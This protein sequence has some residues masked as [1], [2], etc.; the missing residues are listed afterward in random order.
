MAD[1]SVTIMEI[2]KKVKDFV[3]DREWE[4]FHTPRNI[5]ESVV[6]ESA[7]LLEIFQWGL[8]DGTSMETKKRIEEE[9]ADI[10]IYLLNLCNALDMDL[11]DAALA[12]IRKNES[13]YPVSRY[14][15]KARYED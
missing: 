8:E 13:K 11:S 9:V 1:N 3:K 4:R 7:E 6:L 5:A 2:R 12:K 14:R 15:G 10:F